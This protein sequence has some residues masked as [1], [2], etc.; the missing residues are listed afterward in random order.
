MFNLDMSVSRRP[1]S[2]PK[3]EFFDD[4]SVTLNILLLKIIEEAS[5]LSDE[6]KQGAL[7]ILVFFVPLK[8]FGQFLDPSREQCDLPFRAPGVLLGIVELF[9]ELLLFIGRQFLHVRSLS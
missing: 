2:F 9:E 3:S 7:G 8:V 1:R 5:A 6:F 4:R